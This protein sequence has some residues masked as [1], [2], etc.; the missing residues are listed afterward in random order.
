MPIGP[1]SAGELVAFTQLRTTD[2]LA[3]FLGTSQK[4]LTFHLY[5]KHRPSYHIFRIPKATGGVRLIASPPRVIKIWQK[6]VLSCMTAMVVPKGPAHGFILKKSVVTNAAGHVGTNFVLNVDLL[7]FFPSIHFGRIRGVFCHQP[8]GF[9][10]EVSAVLAQICSRNG[11]LPPGAPTSPIISNLICRGLDRD[12]LALARRSRCRYTRYADDITFSTRLRAFPQSI[13][14]SGDGDPIL[15]PELKEILA[16]QDFKVNPQK[17]HV[18]SR[19]ERQEVTGL[20]VNQK[21]NLRRRYIRNVRALLHD[22]QQRGWSSA[23]ERFQQT[24]GLKRR[25]KK[26]NLAAHLKGRLEYLKMVR[27]SDDPAYLTYALRFERLAPSR[28]FGVCLEGRYALTLPIIIEAIWIVLGYNVAGVEVKQGT[29]FGLRGIGLV[30]AAHVFESDADDPVVDWK[31]LKASSPSISYRVNGWQ[32][33]R[34]LDLAIIDTDAVHAATLTISERQIHAGDEITITGFPNW[35]SPADGLELQSVK[36]TQ[37][38][39]VHGKSYILTGGSIREGASGGPMLDE[40]GAVVGVALAGE[41][42]PVSP[43]GGLAI[44]HLQDL[45]RYPLK[46]Q[47]LPRNS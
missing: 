9:G 1:P 25:G 45:L 12:L 17:L 4:R 37:T 26:P 10:A 19:S 32:S 2:D 29:A 21:K 16:A 43:N 44:S 41:R 28:R 6:R 39:I 20:V 42:A 22:W 15:G 14:E 3:D 13:L 27:G 40:F 33:A 36:V 30:S 34:N 46:S 23:E 8:F 47:V 24:V 5:S 35:F 31:V 11:A 7:D 38:K 18:R